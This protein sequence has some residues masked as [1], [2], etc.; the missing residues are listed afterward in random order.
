VT[1]FWRGYAFEITPFAH[2]LDILQYMLLKK[3][4]IFLATGAYSGL[5]PVAPGTAGSLVA[6]FLLLLVPSFQGFAFFTAL[7]VLFVLGVWAA[8][9]AERFY[10]QDDAQQIVIDEIAGMMVSVL[11]LPT[12]WKTCLLA[13]VLFRIFDIAKPFPAKQA[14]KV[15]SLPGKFG[16]DSPLVF[17][18]SG[19]LGV[20][21]DD[22]VAGIYANVCLRIILGLG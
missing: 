3:A 9:E 7:I 6:L 13:F 12:G 20:M 8:S 11:W 18:Y 17:R 21:L 10:K 14:E 2:D 1:V 15:S 4:A 5:S 19:G 16:I 22:V